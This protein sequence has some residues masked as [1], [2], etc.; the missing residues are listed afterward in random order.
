MFDCA[1]YNLDELRNIFAYLNFKFGALGNGQY[2]RQRDW[3][4]TLRF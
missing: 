4:I 3:L 2:E 1:R